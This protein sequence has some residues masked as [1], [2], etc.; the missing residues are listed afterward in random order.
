MRCAKRSRILILALNNEYRVR[1]D[2]NPLGA[3]C[4]DD[5]LSVYDRL[6]RRCPVAYSDKL[7]WSILRYEDVVRLLNEPTTFSNEV[8]SY[9]AVPNGFDPPRHTAYRQLL[10]P[11]LSAERVAPFAPRFREL[12][13]SLVNE[14]R[15]RGDFDFVTE[16]A[17]P[18]SV[19]AQCA[20]MGWEAEFGDY[21]LSW[22]RKSQR[23]TREGDRE[24]LSVVADEFGDLVRDLLRSEQ[25][26]RQGKVL[27]ELSGL[28]LEGSH[29]SEDEII[30]IVR[31]WTV[32]ELGTLS[33]SLSI[34]ARGIARHP[35]VQKKLRMRP[36][37]VPYSIEEFLRLDGPLRSNRRRV[38]EPAKVGG[39]ELKDGGLVT[40]IWPSANRDNSVF[41][42]AESFRWNR[43]LS[44]SLLYGH[45]IHY[46]PGAPLAR[47]E[48]KQAVDVLLGS[49]KW[50]TVP[51][52]DKPVRACYPASGYSFLPLTV[53][54]L[55]L[56][57]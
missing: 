28:T 14:L 52:S 1:E 29:L 25:R 35:N 54:W 48:L 47:L 38:A 8:S 9:P 31:N 57:S 21:F 34:I 13:E 12:A 19:R 42:D 56:N 39:R 43:N 27:A 51:P 15:G 44:R 32:G 26:N 55:P 11:Y 23:A 53:D 41:Q 36:D 16:F 6:R 4:Q 7:G 2:W 24:T 33:A 50:W 49:S 18:F 40:L 3:E 45:G 17:E 5:P 10:D 46:C 37:L 22:M 30:S 20:F